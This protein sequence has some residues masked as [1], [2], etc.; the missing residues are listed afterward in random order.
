MNLRIYHQYTLNIFA[1]NLL[2]MKIHLYLYVYAYNIFSLHIIEN[3][4]QGS[5]GSGC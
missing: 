2:D 1:L 3:S 5:L 4:E